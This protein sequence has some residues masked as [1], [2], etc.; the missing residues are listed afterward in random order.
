MSDIDGT[1]VDVSYEETTWAVDED[2]NAFAQTTEVEGT[3]YD[4]DG[5]GRLR[6]GRRVL[7]RKPQTVEAR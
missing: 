7:V 2:G 4:F 3:A 1:A 6:R 5:D